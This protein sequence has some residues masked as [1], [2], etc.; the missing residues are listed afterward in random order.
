MRY[1]PE[2]HGHWLEL[3]AAALR[4]GMTEDRVRDLCRRRV[5]RCLDLG[6]GIVLVE[7]AILSGAV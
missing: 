4:L 2:R 3:P 7:P 6:D 5:L 1:D